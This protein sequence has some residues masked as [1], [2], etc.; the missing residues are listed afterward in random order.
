MGA[1]AVTAVLLMAIASIP[2]APAW[3]T[4]VSAP[5]TGSFTQCG[6]GTYYGGYS[7]TGPSFNFTTGRGSYSVSASGT[8][9]G[10]NGYGGR[11]Y[12]AADFGEDLEYCIGIEVPFKNHSG[13]RSLNQITVTLGYSVAVNYSFNPGYC[14]WVRSTN[15]SNICDDDAEVGVWFMGPGLRFYGDGYASK[16][17]LPPSSVSCTQGCNRG[18][19]SMWHGVCGYMYETNKSSGASFRN[20]TCANPTNSNVPIPPYGQFNKSGTLAYTIDF[21]L[22]PLNRSADVLLSFLEEF[23]DEVQYQ[24]KIGA[25]GIVNAY[26]SARLDFSI[27]SVK[28]V[29]S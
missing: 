27:H 7:A 12:Y 16:H 22:R 29:E 15:K 20:S 9:G 24:W 4:T 18:G 21:Y 6:G 23:A 11:H 10:T 8:P 25:G 3:S 19:T 26:G 5:L 1:T 13:T 2:I 14:P 28:I 17:S